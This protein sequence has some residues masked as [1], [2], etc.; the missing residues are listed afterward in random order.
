MFTHEHAKTVWFTIEARG[1][2]LMNVMVVETDLATNA[3]MEGFD[4]DFLND[5]VNAAVAYMK[6]N[7]ASIDS[8]RIVPL[9]KAV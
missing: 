8:V 6:A 7:Q 5:L 1:D 3:L 9:V 2:E 4:D